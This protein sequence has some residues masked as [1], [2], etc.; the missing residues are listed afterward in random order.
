MNRDCA[1]FARSIMIVASRE[2]A[3]P[4]RKKQILSFISLEEK[5]DEPQKVKAEI[6]YK[7]A[8]L[9]PILTLG[10]RQ[11]M[12]DSCLPPP[13]QPYFIAGG[14]SEPSTTSETSTCI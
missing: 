11:H 9:Q 13:K 14:P 1:R 6:Q 3:S 5:V 10:K 4:V 7:I 8:M 12:L 2:D